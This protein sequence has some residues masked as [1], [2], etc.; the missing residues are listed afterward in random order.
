MNVA[1]LAIGLT[2]VS[3]LAALTAPA[4]DKAGKPAV[5]LKTVKYA[6]LADAVVQNR[7]KVVIVDF[8]GFF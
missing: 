6:G 1:R 7:G 5:A 4:Q 2:A 8:W 3:L